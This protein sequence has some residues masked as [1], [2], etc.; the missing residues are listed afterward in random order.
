NIR[1]IEEVDGHTFDNYVDW[2][3]ITYA[4]TLTGCP[5][6]SVPA[7]FTD[8][9]LPV[10][11]QLVGRPYG[12]AELLSYAAQLEEILALG[13]MTPMMPMDPASRA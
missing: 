10:G 11:I 13:R 8:S 3:Y 5:A 6:I 12:E 7:A 2:I 1:Y 4:I 9:G